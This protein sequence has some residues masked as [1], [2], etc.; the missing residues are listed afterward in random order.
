MGATLDTRMSGTSIAL[1]GGT[2][3]RNLGHVDIDHAYIVQKRAEC[4]PLTRCDWCV[5]LARVGCMGSLVGLI[6]M[7]K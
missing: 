7:L 4:A 1:N 6:Y 5:G 2:Y 3:G